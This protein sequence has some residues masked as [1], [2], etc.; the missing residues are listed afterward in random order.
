[1]AWCIG[2]GEEGIRVDAEGDVH[3]QCTAGVMQEHECRLRVIGE[4]PVK[5]QTRSIASSRDAGEAKCIY[6]PATRNFLPTSSLVMQS[7][8]LTLALS[9]C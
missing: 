1:M 3:E 6:L 9:T 8:I 4:H 7:S 2:D 5:A